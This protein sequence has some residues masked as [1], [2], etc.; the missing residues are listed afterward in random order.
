MANLSLLG[1]NSRI[2]TPFIKVTIGNYTFG[3]F[4]KKYKSKLTNGI[5]TEMGV[6]YPNYIK[7]LN[8]EKINGK[9]NTYTLR[10]EYPI[11]PGEDP[12]F[13]EK[14]FS[15]VSVSRKIK[16]SYGDISLPK[17][18]YKD[19][20]ALINNISTDFSIESS[21]ISY[22]GQAISSASLANSGS[23]SFPSFTGKPSE[24]IEEILYNSNYGLLDLFYGMISK[25]AV[26]NLGLIPK[27]DATVFVKAKQNISPLDY[28]KY[29]VDC[30]RPSGTKNNSNIQD[31]V[32]ILSICDEINGETKINGKLANLG[33][34]YFK[35]SGLNKAVINSDAY[36]IDI[37]YPSN[38][39]VTSFRLQNNENYSIYYNW[40]KKLNDSEYTIRLNND[41][42]WEQVYAPVISSSSGSHNTYTEDKT[43]WTKVTQY[44]ISAIITLKGLIRPAT[45][46]EYVKL[47]VYF[48]GV[49]HISTGTYII[50]KQAD[51]IDE[52]GYRTT[53][54]LTRIGGE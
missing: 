50:T 5:Y 46:M 10:I 2:E 13:F 31:T 42:E 12:N 36:Y 49:K 33:G 11:R 40:Q 23:Y 3:V 26:R 47:N 54:T 7:S 44:P 52:S 15:S 24:K 8:I 53:L 1:T 21:K 39:I 22:T 34:P 9:V 30:M 18:I 14:I 48:H 41:G 37:G 16:F 32:Y 27:T 28:I 17:Y 43:W 19:E 4:D 38:N 20:E 6:S 51:Q 35:I 25:T 29:L 45:L